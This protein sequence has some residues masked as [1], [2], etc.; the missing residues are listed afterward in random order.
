MRNAPLFPYT[1]TRVAAIEARVHKA[2][3]IATFT[4]YTPVHITRMLIRLTRV[5]IHLHIHTRQHARHIQHTR[6]YVN[7]CMHTAY[8]PQA[9]ASVMVLLVGSGCLRVLSSIV[10]LSS[11]S[12]ISVTLYEAFTPDTLARTHVH[13]HVLVHVSKDTLS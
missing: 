10:V 13:V 6:Q 4:P 1:F 11:A 7:T 12:F 5:C 8:T 9:V 2:H 3:Q